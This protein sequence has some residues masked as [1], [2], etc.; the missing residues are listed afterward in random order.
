[1]ASRFVLLAIALFAYGKAKRILFKYYSLN[2]ARECCCLEILGG[3]V[4]DQLPSS[5]PPVNVSE[6]VDVN[7]T[8]SSSP[9]GGGNETDLLLVDRLVSD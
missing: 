6:T 4:T 1:M 7:N 9:A 2:E 8:Q 3:G 5:L